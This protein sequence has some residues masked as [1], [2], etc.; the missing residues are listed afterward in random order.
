MIRFIEEL[1]YEKR[2]SKL[3]ING[4]LK[5][6]DLFLEFLNENNIKKY[7]EVEYDDIRKYIN[8]LHDLKYNNKTISRHISSL[9][10]FFKYLKNNN[11][12]KNNPVLLICNPKLEKK[13]T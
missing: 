10:S 8:Y 3:T 7:N 9:R 6:L 11:I 2:D 13:I 4:Y 5:D 1:N 12:I